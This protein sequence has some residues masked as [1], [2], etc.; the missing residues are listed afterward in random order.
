MDR[1]VSEEEIVDVAKAA[2][3]HEFVKSLP[4]VKHSYMSMQYIT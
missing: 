1:D 3:I 2:N 4:E